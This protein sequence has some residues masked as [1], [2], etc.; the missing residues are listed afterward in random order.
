MAESSVSFP[1]EG[2]D[3]QP[4][5]ESSMLTPFFN[6]KSYLLL[7]LVMTMSPGFTVQ[8]S[9]IHITKWERVLKTSIWWWQE[10]GKGTDDEMF[11]A[12]E[13]QAGNDLADVYAGVK[14]LDDVIVSKEEDREAAIDWRDNDAYTNMFPHS[15][16]SHPD[17]QLRMPNPW[18]RISNRPEDV[19]RSH[20]RDSQ[21]SDS[22][23][24][25]RTFDL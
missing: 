16:E 11:K 1:G 14:R 10:T 22:P 12:I 5:P 23:D 19:Q 4:R 7:I 3:V 18:V 9:A 20:S 17:H 25:V 21:I 6:R 13:R 15:I 2:E 8:E 24:S